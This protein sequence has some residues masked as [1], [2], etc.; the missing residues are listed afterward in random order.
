MEPLASGPQAGRGNG[1]GRRQPRKKPDRALYIPRAMRKKPEDRRKE[2]PEAAGTK[3]GGLGTEEDEHRIPS[4][5]CDSEGVVETNRLPN[6]FGPDMGYAEVQSCRGCVYASHLGSGGKSKPAPAEGLASTLSSVLNISEREGQNNFKEATSGLGSNKDQALLERLSQ[7]ST[8]A[9]TREGLE[10]SSLCEENQEEGTSCNVVLEDGGHL[11]CPED[12]EQGAPDVITLGPKKNPLDQEKDNRPSAVSENCPFPA[13]PEAYEKASAEAISLKNFDD[14]VL[15]EDKNTDCE[16]RGSQQQPLLE[17]DAVVLSQ[18]ESEGSVLEAP[19]K[20]CSDVSVL[21][22]AQTE[23]PRDNQGQSSSDSSILATELVVCPGLGHNQT[24][25]LLDLEALPC[26]DASLSDNGKIDM[27]LEGGQERDGLD[28]EGDRWPELEPS[29]G[30]QSL[31]RSTLNEKDGV[32]EDDCGAELLEEVTA[33]C[34]YRFG[35]PLGLESSC[36]SGNELASL[37]ESVCS[38]EAKAASA[39][40]V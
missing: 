31:G 11:P 4:V 12:Q 36:V 23:L 5:L 37:I 3:Q 16:E 32:F 38:V 8:A 40:L 9:L 24:P 2:G 13:L 27:V 18:Q 10:D 35:D 33:G 6:T 34:Q 19:D 7:S 28:L 29:A 39:P 14:L 25:S 21:N 1:R 30:D 15:Y 17:E 26:L 22:C 20:S